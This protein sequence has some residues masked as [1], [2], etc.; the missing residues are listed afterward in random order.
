MKTRH[1]ARPARRPA[2]S[3]RKKTLVLRQDLLDRARQ[4]IGARTGTDAVTQA[5]E[6]VVRRHEQIDGICRLAAQCASVGATLV[7]TNT[8]DFRRLTRY[9]PVKVAA[10]FP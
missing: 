3:K 8:A 5:L 2:S 10:P 7:T 4:A 1:A 6:A 9:I